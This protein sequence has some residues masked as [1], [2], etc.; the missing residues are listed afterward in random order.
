MSPR[1]HMCALFICLHTCCKHARRTALCNACTRAYTCAFVAG[2]QQGS[3]ANGSDVFVC[4]RARVCV[5]VRRATGESGERRRRVP[6]ASVLPMS[7]RFKRPQASEKLY[8]GHLPMVAHPECHD[9]TRSAAK[10]IT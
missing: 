6:C 1:A 5:R 4:S 8:N 7:V 9:N 10:D 2:V 3:R